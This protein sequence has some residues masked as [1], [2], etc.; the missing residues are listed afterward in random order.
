M[1]SPKEE[2]VAAAIP[3]PLSLIL[4]QSTGLLGQFATLLNQHGSYFFIFSATL[5]AVA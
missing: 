5:L 1:S 4:D 3:L 2:F